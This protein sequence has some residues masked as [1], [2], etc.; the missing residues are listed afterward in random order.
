MKK[1]IYTLCLTA[2]FSAASN[3]TLLG[4]KIVSYNEAT[5]NSLDVIAEEMKLGNVK[6]FKLKDY[7]DFVYLPI[8]CALFANE[9]TAQRTYDKLNGVRGLTI[10]K[11]SECKI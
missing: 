10:D 6:E 3:A 2:F 5:I 8:I 7:E 1:F 9:A 4:L 11:V